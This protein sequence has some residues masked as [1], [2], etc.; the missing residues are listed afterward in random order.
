LKLLG[1]IFT[2]QN[3]FQEENHH[4]LQSGNAC[5]HKVKYLLSSSLLS[6]TIKINIQRI[7]IFSSVLYGYEN[8]SL[9]LK[10]EHRLSA[11]QSK[12]L[13]RIFG[14]KREEVTEEWREQYSE[15]LNDLYSSL[16]TIRVIKSRRIRWVWL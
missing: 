12:V 6:K 14:P 4:T 8:W 1:K 9:T 2:N 15:Q 13:R 16:N 3:S 5:C 7:V 11:F 10:D